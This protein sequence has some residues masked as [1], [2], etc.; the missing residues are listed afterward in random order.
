[1]STVFPTVVYLLCFLTSGACAF[2]LFRNYQRTG[3]RL[4]LWGALCFLFLAANNL[5]VIA[6]LL[7]LPSYDLAVP[8]LALSLMAAVILLFG[9]IWDGER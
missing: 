7:V 4:L 8:R 1:M 5:I 6:D 2:L 3:M 9:F